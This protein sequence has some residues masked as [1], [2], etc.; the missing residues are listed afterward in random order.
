M[1]ALVTGSSGFIG[2]HLAAELAK[3]SYEV[4]CLIRKTSRRRFLENLNVRF[5]LG[6]C[7]DKESL[8]PA[9]RGMDYV[10]HLAG[11]INALDWKTYF[12]TNTQGTQN[13]LEA[14]LEENP[15]LQKFVFVSSI[16][17]C[18]PSPRGTALREDD[19]CRPVSD[20]GRSKLRAEQI[21]LGSTDRLP[22]TIIRPPN[23]I[24]PR[25]KELFEFIKLLHKGIKPLIGTGEPQTSLASVDDIVKAIILT[26]VHPRSCGQIYFVTDG[27]A[28]SWRD[29]AGTVAESLGPRRF[30]LKIPYAVQYVLA[31]L[32]EIGSTMKRTSPLFTRQNI[33][34]TRKYCWIY[35]S[36]KIT[37]ELGFK[38]SLEMEETIRKTVAWYKKEGMIT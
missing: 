25:Q 3:R 27:R 14:C 22:L 5:V 4:Q 2:S 31:A 13:L 7:R 6:D 21:V 16:S 36:S 35:D 33:S 24:G 19:D 15:R 23:V 26:A 34:A 8:R 28:Y 18:G 30:Y 9:V 32:F 37:N 17:A 1:K 29:I 38:P 12:E 11:V 10:F 20:Y